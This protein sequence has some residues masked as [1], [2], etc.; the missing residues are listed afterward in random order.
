MVKRLVWDLLS[1]ANRMRVAWGL[2]G[3]DD[4]CDLAFGF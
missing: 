2:L 4:S 1:E 3:L